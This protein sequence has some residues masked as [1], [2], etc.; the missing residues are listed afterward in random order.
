LLLVAGGAKARVLA[1][2][3]GGIPDPKWPVTALLTHPNLTVLA[4][5]ELQSV[6][7]EGV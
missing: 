7:A 1:A 4:G 3:R 2:F 5:S 6:A